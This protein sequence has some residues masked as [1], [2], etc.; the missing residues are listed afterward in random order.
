M[1]LNEAREV[2]DR[3]DKELVPLIEQRMEAVVSV[4]K[5]KKEHGL[6]VLDASREKV[7][8]EK[9]GSYVENKDF[10]AS[11]QQIFQA[12]MDTTKEYQQEKIID[13]D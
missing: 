4:G 1:D 2:I 6:P 7:V 11:I 5:Y 3:V 10:E 9:I 13:K 12:V 8:L